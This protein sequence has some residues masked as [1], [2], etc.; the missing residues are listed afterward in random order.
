MQ[1]EIFGA[2]SV[3]LYKSSANNKFSYYRFMVYVVYVLTIYSTLSTFSAIG[4]AAC[5]NLTTLK[6]L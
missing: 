6:C 4:Y 3:T 2:L 1:V 5:I